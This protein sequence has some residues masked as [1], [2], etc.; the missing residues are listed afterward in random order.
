LDSDLTGENTSD[1]I[2]DDVIVKTIK[3]STLCSDTQDDQ[4]CFYNF[5]EKYRNL[6][7][8]AYKI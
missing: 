6:P 4:E 3:E 5:R 1:L 2:D 8:L 7:Y